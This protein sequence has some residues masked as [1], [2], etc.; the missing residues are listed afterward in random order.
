MGVP[1]V[2]SVGGTHDKVTDASVV[3]SA[4]AMLKAGRLASADPSVTEIVTAAN[5]PTWL[6]PGV[7]ERRAVT[8]VPGVM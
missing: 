5:V 3:L 2:F 6:A 4:T 7:P 1:S 8:V